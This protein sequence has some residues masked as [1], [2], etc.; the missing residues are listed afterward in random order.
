MSK[1]KVLTETEIENVKKVREDFQILVGRIGEVEIGI[2]NLQKNKKTL[3]VELDRIQQEEIRIAKELEIKYGKGN[4]SL[5]TG[6]FT[7]VE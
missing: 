4:V 1:E 6:K 5:E 3:E 2:L 7:P